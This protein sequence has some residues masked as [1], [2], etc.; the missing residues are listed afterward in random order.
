MMRCLMPLLAAGMLWGQGVAPKPKPG[1]ADEVEAA[2]ARNLAAYEK[3]Y[4]PQKERLTKARAKGWVVIVEGMILPVDAEGNVEPAP[5][6]REVET[7]A[8]R[9]HPAAKHRFVF[10]VGEDG[11]REHF[12][13]IG[14]FPHGV[15]QG[16]VQAVMKAT[17]GEWWSTAQQIWLQ[18]GTKEGVISVADEKGYPWVFFDVGTP[19]GSTKWTTHRFGFASAFSG[20]AVVSRTTAR[21]HALQLW[22]IP[23]TLALN[24][25][26]QCRRA[27]A[28][29][30]LK[31]PAGKE[32]TEVLCDVAVWPLAPIEKK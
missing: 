28:L 11:S 13:T 30:R 9:L 24:K 3:R 8:R 5:T 12:Y 20:P 23:G 14:E 31:K 17:G 19:D 29:F 32:P 27:R 18:G 22:E 10:Q 6:W 16:L 4:K 26:R 2:R 21:L 7:V 25:T 1:R 15:G